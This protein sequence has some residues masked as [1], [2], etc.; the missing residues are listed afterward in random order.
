MSRNVVLDYTNFETLGE[1]KNRYPDSTLVMRKQFIDI[2]IEHEWNHGR[3]VGPQLGVCI[4][5][6]PKCNAETI[7]RTTAT[8]LV[9]SLVPVLKTLIEAY[10][11]ELGKLH[12]RVCFYKDPR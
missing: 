9:N 3:P 1:I 2:A 4:E 6:N 10:A 8:G 11:D 12:V 7:A 5:L